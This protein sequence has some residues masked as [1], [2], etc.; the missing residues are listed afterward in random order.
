LGIIIAVIHSFISEKARNFWYFAFLVLG[1]S[2]G[3]RDTLT[4]MLIG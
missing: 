3:L 2:P 1:F 4:I